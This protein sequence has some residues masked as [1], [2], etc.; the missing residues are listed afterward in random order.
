MWRATGKVRYWLKWV[1]FISIGLGVSACGDDGSIPAQQNVPQ[2]LQATAGDGAVSL[3]WV[4]VKGATAYT[5]YWNTNSEV[6]LNKYS[7]QAISTTQNSYSHNGLSNGR[8]YRYVVTATVAGVESGESNLAEAQPQRTPPAKPES[9]LIKPEDGRVTLRW[10]AVNQAE[11]YDLVWDTS[12]SL[13]SARRIQGISSPYVHRG[14]SNGQVVY[15]QLLAVNP[16][17][18]VASDLLSARPNPR[19]PAAPVGLGASAANGSININWSDVS[20]GDSYELFWSNSPGITLQS[21]RVRGVT[22]PYIHA[23]LVNGQIYHYRIRAL[24][25]AGAGNLSQEFQVTAGNAGSEVL[26]SEGAPPEEPAGVMLE[27]ND[28]RLDINWQLRQGAVGYN[29][30]WST[31]TSPGVPPVITTDSNKIANISPPYT[32]SGLSN[33]LRYYYRISAIN[34]SGESTLSPMVSQMPEA[35]QPGVPGNVSAIGG[36]GFIGVRW[37]RVRDAQSYTLYYW[38]EGGGVVVVPNLTETLYR[39]NGLTNGTVYHLQLTSTHTQSGESPRSAE[40]LVTPQVDPVVAPVAVQAVPG[41]AQVELKF[42][43]SAYSGLPPGKTVQ[44]YRI[45]TS[46]SPGVVNQN[47]FT[48]I[49]VASISG[50]TA[51]YVFSGLTNG[52][53]YYYSVT[54]VN[55]GGESPLSREVW[56]QPQLTV[57]GAPQN[58]QIREGDSELTLSWQAPSGEIL[59]TDYNVYW[60]QTLANGQRTQPVVIPNVGNEVSPGQFQYTLSGLTNNTEYYIL[61]KAFNDGGEGL[62]SSEL[63]GVPHI[64]APTGLVSALIAQA[65]DSQVTLSWDWDIAT[66]GSVPSEYRLYWSTQPSMELQ[67]SPWIDGVQSGFVHQGLTN[68]QPYYYRV[69]AKNDGGLGPVSELVQATPLPNVPGRVGGLQAQGSDGA[70][71]LTWDEVPDADRY[72]VYWT[73]DSGQPLDSWNRLSG[74][75]PGDQH[76]GLDNGITYFYVITAANIGGESDSSQ[77]VSATPQVPAPAAPQG[78]VATADNTQVILDWS[79]QAGLSYNVYWVN[80]A[81]DDPFTQGQVISNVRPSY[82]HTGLVNGSVYR[83]VVTAVNAGGESAPGP[84]ASATPQAYQTGAPRNLS[85]QAGDGQVVVS[86]QAAP[87]ATINTR[88]TLYVSNTAGSGTSG[89]PISNVVSPY[90]HNGLSNGTQYYYVVTATEDVESSASNEAVAQPMPPAPA[91]PSG[92]FAVAG[93]GLVDLGWNAAQNAESYTLQWDVVANF[94]NANIV[95]LGN[96]RTFRH[97]GRTNGT[98][99]YY[100]L[101]AHNGAVNSAYSNSVTATPVAPVVN[102]PPVV[103]IVSPA[104]DVTIT[105][106]QGVEFLANATD[107]E[108]DARGLSLS[109]QWDFGAGSGIQ[110]SGLKNPGTRRFQL[111]GSFTVNLSVRDSEGAIASISRV[112]T[113]NANQA[114][115]STIL[116]PTQELLINIGDTVNFSGQGQDNDNHLPLTY[117]W[118]FGN[119]SGINDSTLLNPGVQ[120]FSIS[121]TFVVQ[122]TVT[123]NMG[124]S[125][126]SPAAT[127]VRVNAPP[128]IQ[129][130]S[131]APGAQITVG[132]DVDFQS[133]VTD[134]EDGTSGLTYLWDFGTS[135]IA[136]STVEDPG[137]HVFNTA[138]TYQVT[139]TVTDQH[140]GQSQLSRTISVGSVQAPVITSPV[141]VEGSHAVSMDEDNSPIAYVPFALTATDPQGQTL[142]W[143]IAPAP[144]PQPQLGAPVFSNVADGGVSAIL[145]YSPNTDATGVDSFDVRVSNPQGGFADLRIQISINAQNDLPV[146]ETNQLTISNGQALVLN[147]LAQP[148]L[149]V[150]DVDNSPQQLSYQVVSVSNGQFELL[151]SPAVAVT[152]F[153]HQQILDQQVRFV[154][155][156]GSLAPTYSLT[157]ADLNDVTAPSEAAISFTNLEPAQI[158]SLDRYGDYTLGWSTLNAVSCE[159]SS[160]QG[161]GIVSVDTNSLSAGKYLLALPLDAS[162]TLTCQGG[163][164]GPVSQSVTAISSNPFPQTVG[165]YGSS[166]PTYSWAA[167][168]N[169]TSPISYVDRIDFNNQVDSYCSQLGYVGAVKTLRGDFSTHDTYYLQ[170]ND[171]I[172]AGSGPSNKITF[173]PGDLTFTNLYTNRRNT[174]TS[175]GDVG[176]VTIG[177]DNSTIAQNVPSPTSGV[178]PM[179]LCQTDVRLSESAFLP[180]TISFSEPGPFRQVLGL[181]TSFVNTAGG[182]RGLGAIRYSSSNPNVAT[183]DPDS[184][185]VTIVALGETIITATKAADAFA[186]AEAGYTL[187]VDIPRDIQIQSLIKTS[188]QTLSWTTAYAVSCELTNNQNSTVVNLSLEDVSAAEYLYTLAATTTFTLTCL[189][190]SGTTASLSVTDVGTNLYPQTVGYYGIAGSPGNSWAA[191]VNL[192]SPITFTGISDF[193][194][195]VD[196][197]CMGLGYVGVV[198]TRIG[199]ISVDATYYLH[200][201]AEI[202]M[203][204]S[205]ITFLPS[206]NVNNV[207]TND[208]N[209]SFGTVVQA[210]IGDNQA[211]GLQTAVS[212]TSGVG[213]M[214]LC[215]TNLSLSKTTDLFPQTIA[216]EEPGPIRKVP[217]FDSGFTNTAFGPGV[218]QVSYESSDPT[219][220]SVNPSTGLVT[221]LGVGTTTI[222]ATK[223]ADYIFQQAQASYV[224]NVDVPQS[225]NMQSF[226]KFSEVELSWTVAAAVSCELSQDMDSNVI[227]LS[228]DQVLSGKFLHAL[229]A[230]TTFVL[231]C[232][233]ELG[234]TGN[235]SVTAIGTNPFP[236]TRGYYGS[237]STGNSWV[238][239]VNLSNPISFG[240]REHFNSQVDGYCKGLGYI[241]SAKTQ[242]GHFSTH[243]KYYLQHYDGIIAGSGP[244]NKA[245]LI[246]GGAVFTNVYANRRNTSSSN[247]DVGRV[248]VGNN[249]SSITQN[250]TGIT[251]GV[252]QMVFCQTDIPIEN[253]AFLPQTISFLEPGPIRKVLGVDANFANTASGGA[254]FGSITYA[255]SD[256]AVATVDVN[257]NITIIGLGVT[258]I[259]AVKAADIYI[260]AQAS[261]E[262]T[263]DSPQP[264]QFQEFVKTSDNTLRWSSSF[265]VSCDITNDQN[266]EIIT[267]GIESLAAGSFLHFYPPNTTLTLSCIDETGALL[268]Q[269]VTTVV[270]NDYPQTVGYYGSLGVGNSW[271]AIVNLSSPISFTDRVDFNNQVD[272]YCAGLGYIGVVKTRTGDFSTHELHY[273]QGSDGIIAGNGPSNKVTYIPG[274]S[275]LENVYANRRNINISNGDVG[276]V[277]VGNNESRIT[278]SFTGGSTSGLDQMV[279]C[280]TNL[281]VANTALL[282]QSIS[283]IQAGPIRKVSG[284]DTL[285]TNPAVDGYGSG[286]ISYSSSNPGV[287]MVDAVTGEV[288]ILSV[289]LT[290]ITA[291]KAQDQ[292]YRSAQASYELN[293]D[294]PRSLSVQNFV[295]YNEV[296]LSWET[297]YA[298]SCEISNDQNSIVLALD[299]NE[300]VSG[301]V[302]HGLPG[303]TVFTL[304][305]TGE[306]GGVGNV[307]ATTGVSLFPDTMGYYGSVSSLDN[308]WVAIVNLSAPI[309]FTDRV[310]F[311]NQVD[312]YCIGLG[313][314]GAPKTINGHFSTN[315]TY[316]LQGSDGIIAGSGPSQKITIIPGG[317]QYTNVYTNRRNY[318]VS[319]LGDAGRAVIGN[320]NS[321]ISQAIPSPTS[322]LDPMVLCQT[323]K[324]MRNI[325]FVP[326]SIVF[327][328]PSPTP[329]SL[330]VTPTYSNAVASG[331]GTGALTY[332]SSDPAVA[333]VDQAGT[334]TL[335]SV[336]TTTISAV[337]AADRQ[338]METQASYVLTINP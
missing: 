319:S 321:T 336:G 240:S 9:V 21:N 237:Y 279:L 255:S 25:A 294:I 162:I 189:G 111:P 50:D 83:Y 230:A 296:E 153:T 82:T 324:S 215:Q 169:L 302:L 267:L 253:T 168:V 113:V 167:I 217:Q 145:G 159:I 49:N 264:G 5:L 130:D 64:I 61:V 157:V 79:T 210:T 81:V 128:V 307:T 300:S 91:V 84:V 41:D 223:A 212:P 312:N 233:G 178:D 146:I 260:E 309:S 116:Q 150:S 289:G 211:Y 114:P 284:L 120:T 290:T 292:Y 109:Y 124:L 107:S 273:L 301:S 92:L 135:G 274:N 288:T 192:T 121:G 234:G 199:N 67:N 115:E 30:Y 177:N 138:G 15:Y 143:S 252:D 134:P 85:A 242:T 276:R 68:G 222:T 39:V 12:S 20:N 323:D 100:R 187:T 266:S 179:V 158:L 11:R 334:V 22:S 203:G 71:V 209:Y 186:Q 42:G 299:R 54:A 213:Q 235:L 93:D 163:A 171:G 151:S 282:P 72:F 108:D 140:G 112:V 141:A 101:Q 271:A 36:D 188:S 191:I 80:N 51:S 65:Q 18:E 236:Q 183:V 250:I 194:S 33:G 102:T 181:D 325:A 320:N 313:Y 202:L 295:I 44:A 7:G 43:V 53:R 2:L 19:L 285:F 297:L 148:N 327:F 110:S 291:T 32:H 280:Q 263:V 86:W 166:S 262:L 161:A 147:S 328:T 97:S 27:T 228:R 226:E 98:T 185:V 137:I 314:V 316:Y 132:S 26:P 28:G 205:V 105:V 269:S 220:A 249:A 131:P 48:E 258:T 259:T 229:P 118:R 77:I 55:A 232:T 37:N 238:A 144:S 117:R 305:C 46:T 63:G 23:P 62:S 3:T 73:V 17:G 193:S 218:G 90:V 172:I 129:I 231:S 24:N 308:S 125:D 4:Q 122:F 127:I 99:Y 303:T 281:F 332:T 241:G 330:A 29:I 208:Q 272:S 190:E 152:S 154:H 156:L 335:L 164:G 8:V 204:A 66:Q 326:Q 106:G 173:I 69:V 331:F 35:L 322:G 278:Q 245:T 94:S 219:V 96:V 38:P 251:A 224:L 338:F 88:Y 165:Y 31:E 95:P 34:D 47:S 40:V 57:P 270:T 6:D 45:Y 265:M 60:S 70:V 176:R 247:G 243:N 311:N 318:N 74:L 119:S 10:N 286:Q 207:F 298:T 16:G 198:K 287:A 248:T 76:G 56:A 126:A 257:G 58:L 103:Q 175:N 1:A 197:Y 123:D 200:G 293:V 104:G 329:V 283:F 184:G 306:L 182:G 239:I 133:T 333:T 275:T 180:Q 310:D 142:S 246:P 14:L 315:S 52:R 206:G 337:K 89:A 136:S 160:D 225:L 59:V 221:M 227:P 196:S 87:A 256:P 139:L 149:V 261:Y 78:L 216:F 277:V 201:G 75:N 254:G 214:V 170:G 317:V 13:A 244:G 195:Q 304:T 155:N 268:N 174:N